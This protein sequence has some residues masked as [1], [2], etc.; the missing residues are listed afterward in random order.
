MSYRHTRWHRCPLGQLLAPLLLL[1]ALLTCPDSAR[2]YYEYTH[3]PQ[4]YTTGRLADVAWHPSGN[5]ALIVESSGKVL[6]V[7]AD[8]WGVSQVDD[9][10]HM[11]FA[12]L[13]F[14]SAG[15]EALLVGYF[16]D[17]NSVQEGR[18]YRWDHGSGTL[19]HLA[20]C[21]KPGVR[22]RGVA[23]R[24]DADEAAVIGYNGAQIIYVYRYDPG[25]ESLSIAAATNS[26]GPY[27]FAWRHDGDEALIPIG[28]NDAEVIAYR[29]PA[30]SENRLLATTYNGS[31]AMAVDYFPGQNFAL[32][33]DG[34]ANAFKWDG[35]WTKVDLPTGFYMA[36]LG[37]NSDG[38]RALLAGR[39]C[40]SS[41]L[42]LRAVEF[43]AQNGTFTA[44][45]FVDVSIPGFGA[46]PWLG[47]SSSYMNGVAFRP[48]RC[49]GL[50][51]GNHYSW[52]NLF[53]PIAH[54]VDI[55]GADCLAGAD[56]GSSDA[57]LAEDAG[58][59]ADSA[60]PPGD[61]AP[62]LDASPSDLG[63][64]PDSGAPADS[65]IGGDTLGTE[66][67]ASPDGGAAILQCLF[68]E[69][70][71]MGS[72]CEDRECQ[73]DCSTNLDCAGAQQCSERGRCLLPNDAGA[74]PD[75]GASDAQVDGCVGAGC[76]AQPCTQDSECGPGFYCQGYCVPVCYS[77]EDCP[78]DYLC[79][80]GGRCG[81]P[82]AD[83]A[84]V[85]PEGCACRGGLVAPG[86]ALWLAALLLWRRRSRWLA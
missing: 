24:P 16:N 70:C 43:Q 86:P 33:I 53:A 20:D 38:S 81:L 10:D 1:G 13:T 55:R 83:P 37:F 7:G 6:R 54:F 52:D 42:T 67:D 5:Y 3:L 84:P 9:V 75:T 80:A 28:E 85:E 45:D 11:Q 8:D 66:Q 31:N 59:P 51:V 36:G 61:A 47:G 17:G 63:P 22:F 82:V 15:N 73:R 60:A 26:Y 62:G 25:L 18:V 41:N 34:A 27:D 64:L 23:Y 56:A 40:C 30:P 76:A 74:D 46:S 21:D 72:Y 44:S 77:D 68:D 50:M 2:A 48:G 19:S 29:P 32:L 35:T 49:E 78:G 14:A 39:A 58:S 79:Q 71:F 12:H 65:H 69:D 57:N 4:L